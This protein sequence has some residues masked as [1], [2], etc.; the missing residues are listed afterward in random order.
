MSKDTWNTENLNKKCCSNDSCQKPDKIQAFD[1]LFTNNRIQIF[2][3]LLPY[4]E[5][6]MQK[7]LAIYIKYME[8]Q[9]TLTYFK[10][11]PDAH[12]PQSSKEDTSQICNE[13]LPFCSGPQ[14]RQ[15]EQFGNMFSNMNQMWEMIDMMNM[16]KD[17]FP[18]GFSFGEDENGNPS[19]PDISQIMQMFGASF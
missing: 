8:F 6:S 4:L 7:S 9:Y 5:P 1:A 11:Y 12:M 13:I 14:K 3:I 2:K 19:A 17:M 15:I 18:D 10:Q 16:I